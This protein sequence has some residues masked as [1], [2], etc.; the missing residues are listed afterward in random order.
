MKNFCVRCRK[1]DNKH[2]VNGLK[3]KW[4]QT[5][6]YLFYFIFSLRCVIFFL[7]ISSSIRDNLFVVSFFPSFNSIQFSVWIYLSISCVCV[8]MSSC[9]CVYVFFSSTLLMV[10][11]HRYWFGWKKWPNTLVSV[12]CILTIFLS[13]MGFELGT[14][15]YSPCAQIMHTLNWIV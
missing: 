10:F 3:V 2:T 6:L 1:R 11:F 14:C 15:F 9:V 7:R 5:I 12:A 4:R 13:C 8:C